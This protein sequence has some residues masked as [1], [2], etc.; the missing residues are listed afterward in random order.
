MN[1]YFQLP[2]CGK[3]FREAMSSM[4]RGVVKLN[5]VGGEEVEV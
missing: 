4:K 2:P 5:N 3:T 1:E